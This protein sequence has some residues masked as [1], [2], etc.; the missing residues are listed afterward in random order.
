ME[1][2]LMSKIKI[3]VVR[4]LTRGEI[5]GDDIPEYLPNTDPDSRC[6]YHVAGQ[7]YISVDHGYPEPVNNERRFCHWAFADI[8]KILVFLDF[9]NKYHK[10]GGSPST[11]HAPTALRRSS[12]SS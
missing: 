6:R 4:G 2:I 3:T 5:F 1:W 10:V 9:G 12:S 11:A 7:E 8:Q